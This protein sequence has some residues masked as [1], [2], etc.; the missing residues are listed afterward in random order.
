MNRL[1]QKGKQLAEIKHGHIIPIVFKNK[2]TM[3]KYNDTDLT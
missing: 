3:M 2:K 1:L